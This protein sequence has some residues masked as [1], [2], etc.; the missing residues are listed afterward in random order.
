MVSNIMKIQNDAKKEQMAH[1]GDIL[2]LILNL[3]KL[4]MSM[5]K[6]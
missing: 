5:N 2:K 3:K 1:E 4:I 6:D